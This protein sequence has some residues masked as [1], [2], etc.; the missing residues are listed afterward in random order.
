MCVRARVCAC[1]G[2]MSLR[3]MWELRCCHLRTSLP[4]PPLLWAPHC[5][6]AGKYL[7]GGRGWTHREQFIGTPS[8]PHSNAQLIFSPKFLNRYCS[9]NL[10]QYLCS[11]LQSFSTLPTAYSLLQGNP[12]GFFYSVSRWGRYWQRKPLNQPVDLGQCRHSL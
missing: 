9:Q 7:G 11:T 3:M 8:A 5:Q 10:A 6:K 12:L 1:M 2:A 4:N